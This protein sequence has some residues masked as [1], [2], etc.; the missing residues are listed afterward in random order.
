[1]SLHDLNARMQ[2]ATIKQIAVQHQTEAIIKLYEAA[3]MMNNT[4]LMEQYRDQLHTLLDVKLD[5][6]NDIMELSRQLIRLAGKG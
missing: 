5:T 6:V 4:V 3:T 1:M 2:E